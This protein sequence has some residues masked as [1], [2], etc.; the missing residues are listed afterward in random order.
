MPLAQVADL[1]IVSGPAMLRDENGFLASY[2][3]V[4]V[5]GR[6]IGGYVKEA[7]RV[8]REQVVAAGRLRRCSGAG[9]TRTC[10]AWSSA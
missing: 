10:C 1:K 8:V 2:V 5:A 9:S 6:D 4:D 3:Y 7:K